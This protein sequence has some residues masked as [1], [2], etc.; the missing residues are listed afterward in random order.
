MK[1][2]IIIA[3][4]ILILVIVWFLSGYFLKSKNYIKVDLDNNENKV[5][6]DLNTFDINIWFNVSYL[7]K[8]D[9]IT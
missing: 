6:T 3:L 8:M 2:S 1:K 7:K 4:L 5:E 9:N